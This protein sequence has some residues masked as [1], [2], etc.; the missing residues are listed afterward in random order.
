MVY[1]YY[2]TLHSAGIKRVYNTTTPDKAISKFCCFV[3]DIMR[4]DRNKTRHKQLISN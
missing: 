3:Y 4:R 2:Q 1:H